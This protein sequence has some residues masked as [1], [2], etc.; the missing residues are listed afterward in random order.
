[1]DAPPERQLQLIRSYPDLGRM[2]QTGNAATDLG[3]PPEE[4]DGLA[5]VTVSGL[6]AESI[7]D[8]SAA[9]LDRL[10][11]KEYESFQRL[12]Q[13]YREKFGFPLI[14]AVRGDT[15]EAILSNGRARL[16]NSPAQER[17]T[18]LVEIVKIANFRLQDL[19]DGAPP[20]EVV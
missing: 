18:A 9:G 10:S 17:M 2:A 6:G 14:T 12:N 11:P 8:Q 7:R 3:L 13:A 5:T 20:A 16:E 19:V 4:V 15:K 1:M